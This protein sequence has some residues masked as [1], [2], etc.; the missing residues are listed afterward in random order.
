[1][2]LKNVHN[3]IFKNSMRRPIFFA[4]KKFII[5]HQEVHSLNLMK[6][7]KLTLKITVRK[8]ER[9]KEKTETPPV[10]FFLVVQ[11]YQSGS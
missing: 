3:F 1:M 6:S 2:H 11:F 5:S 9:Y 4:S 7:L 10:V 8:I